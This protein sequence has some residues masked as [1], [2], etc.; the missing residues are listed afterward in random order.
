MMHII[1]LETFTLNTFQGVK[2]VTKEYAK[3][4]FIISK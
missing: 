3:Y 1:D 4:D 2:Q